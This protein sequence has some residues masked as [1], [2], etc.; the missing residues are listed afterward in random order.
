MKRRFFFALATIT[1]LGSLLTVASGKPPQE[2][3]PMK[4][5]FDLKLDEASAVKIA[6]VIFVKVYG[7]D[8]LSQRP[9]KVRLEADDSIF[10]IEGTLDTSK[11]ARGGVGEI[12]IKRS[13]AEVVSMMHGK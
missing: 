10:H 11:E 1:G 9:W 7:E 13:N 4:L 2:A 3:K 8:V 6:E 12:K 5:A